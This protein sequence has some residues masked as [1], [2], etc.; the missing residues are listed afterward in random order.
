MNN[1]EYDPHLVKQ[2]LTYDYHD[3]GMMKWH[4]FYL[5]D[6]TSVLD[7]NTRAQV[8][9]RHE[10]HIEAMTAEMIANTINDAI[11]K[12]YPVQIDKAE[13]SIEGIVPSKIEG[14]IS[15]WFGSQIIV[16]NEAILIEEIYAIKKLAR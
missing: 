12:C 14:L 15:G 16:A 5:S 11:I 2:F 4:G 8:R 13:R 1:D 9:E 7:K 3:R 6:H 10:K